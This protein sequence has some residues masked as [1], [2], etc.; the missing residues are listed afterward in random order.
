M[1][2]LLLYVYVPWVSSGLTPRVDSV[3]KPVCELCGRRLTKVK[4]H[5]P[6]GP[7]HAC[8]P[9]CR[10]L[11]RTINDREASVHAESATSLPKKKKHKRTKSDPGQLPILTST[12]TRPHRVTAPKPTIIKS[13][14][15]INKP[16]INL[17][18]L[19]DEA[20]A[21]RIAL[22]EEETK[23]GGQP[24]NTSSIVWE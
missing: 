5:R 12:R 18:A 15:H 13:K 2:C 24:A 23:K 22:I 10:T 7:G 3:G 21:R 11:K 4:H 6:Y 16:V 9:R 8:H 17:S 1:W 14:Q 19:L 20:H